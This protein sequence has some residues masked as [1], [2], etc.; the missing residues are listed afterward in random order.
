MTLT[1]ENAVSLFKRHPLNPVVR[2]EGKGWRGAVTFNPGVIKK[3][4]TYYLFERCAGNLRPFHCYIGLQTSKDGVHFEPASDEP[5]VSPVD[6][7]S[8][9]G[10]VQDPRVTELEG[11][12]YLTVA[13][14]PY[15][16]ASI[17]T[18][19]GVPESYQVDYPGFSGKDEDNQTRSGM[20]VSEDLKTWKFHS[21]ISP[22]EMDDRNVILFPEKIAGKYWVTRRPSDFVGTQANHASKPKGVMISHSEDLNTWSDPESLLVPAF[23]WGDNRLGGSTPPLKTEAGWLLFLSRS[24][25]HRPRRPQS[26]LPHGSCL[27]RFR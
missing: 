25:K 16:W 27:A 24:T 13:Y 7:G 8:E 11:K 12:Y 9:Y 1:D 10:S 5:V 18:G 15:S 3:D 26:M 6:L 17:P 21:W 22:K 19:V 20:L 23:D 14:R 2:P 4:G